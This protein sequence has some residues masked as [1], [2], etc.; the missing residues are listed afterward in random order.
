M[1]LKFC[2]VSDKTYEATLESS[3]IE[4]SKSLLETIESTGLEFPYGC[5]VGT[6]GCCW[7]AVK[8]GQVVLE[9]PDVLEADTLGRIG[10]DPDGRLACRAKIKKGSCEGI[11]L[12]LELPK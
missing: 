9:A 3:N 4:D 5:R 1:G 2:V 12:K 7:V 6:C 11:T 8:E 10:G